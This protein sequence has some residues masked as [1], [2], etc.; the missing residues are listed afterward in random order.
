MSVSVTCSVVFL[1]VVT[2]TDSTSLPPGL[3]ADCRWGEGGSSLHCL[4]LN[5]TQWAQLSLL[6]PASVSSL[7]RL[8]IVS[9]DLPCL[10][11]SS[12]AHWP[13][14][15][16]ISVRHSG[17]T[18]ALC[19]GTDEALQTL[20]LTSLDLS[21]NKI[22]SLGDSFLPLN[23]LTSLNLS[24]NKLH[25]VGAVFK[26]F[27]K[28]TQLDLSHNRLSQLDRRVLQE[29]PTFSLS[30]LD[31][32]H[33]PWPCLPSLS[34]LYSWSLS[35]PARLRDSISSSSYCNIV[36]S[37]T[38]Q[39]AP[40]MTV[41]EHYTKKVSPHCHNSCSCN[42]YHFAAG[43]NISYTVI[44]NCTNSS[45][46]TFPSLPSQTTVLDLSHNKLSQDSL[47]LLDVVRQNYLDI[48]SLI[49]SHNNIQSIGTKLLKLKLHR[50]F[51]ADHNSLTDIPYDFSQLLQKYDTMVISLANNPW[52]CTCNAQ[53]TDTVS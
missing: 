42:F 49:L 32:S 19:Q 36:N 46:T 4:N 30:H 5:R 16:S 31:I 7:A 44:V 13:S 51:K 10:H 25:R 3:E 43:T 17:L 48:T 53:I 11:L 50:S 40:L 34:W 9:S 8:E 1:M 20:K 23:G 29:L 2:V 35:L 27:H 14:L 47:E 12:L 6:S 24:H 33:N 38:G 39:H 15:S 26:E 41:M 22:R 52:H 21:H 37:P 45:L 28:L 18:K